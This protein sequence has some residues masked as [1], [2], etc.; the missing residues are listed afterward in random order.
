MAV[1]RK[2]LIEEWH[3]TD[4]K[5]NTPNNVRAGSDKYITW[6]CKECGHVWET[7]AKSRAIKHTGCPKC[8]E[9]IMSDSQNW[10]FIFT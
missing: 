7:Q 9:G 8:H 2:D 3:S 6:R 4:N 5:S 1:D 10:K